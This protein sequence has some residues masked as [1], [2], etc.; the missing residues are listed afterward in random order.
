MAYSNS[1]VNS[2]PATSLAVSV[3]PNAGDKL[4]FITVSDSTGNSISSWPSG[5]VEEVNQVTTTD[6]S[7]LIVAVKES[8]TGSETT[9]TAVSDQNIIGCVIALSGLAASGRAFTTDVANDNTASVNN[10]VTSGSV[11]PSGDGAEFLSILNIDVTSGLDCSASFSNTGSLGAWTNRVDQNSGFHNL[12]A[13][14]AIQTTAGAVTVTGTSSTGGATAGVALATFGFLPGSSPPS[15]SLQP[16]DQTTVDGG[17][18]SFGATVTGATSYQW[19]TLA[20]S[21]GAW[22]NVSGGTGGTSDDYTTPT[23]TRSAD[24]GRVW[25]LRASNVSGT[26]YSNTVNAFVVEAPA[27][28]S[29]IGLVVG[30]EKVG[31]GMVG[32]PLSVA[33]PVTSPAETLFFGHP[34]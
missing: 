6:S 15:I 18:A 27:S 32:G 23:L 28:Y 25:R 24:A 1:W 19:E 29:G 9:L 12:V 31:E 21:G 2:T 13:A 30:A 10:A 16:T 5:F 20:P 26:V 3:S 34:F 11:T 7:K 4:I 22:A 8:A 14:T 17:T 33:P